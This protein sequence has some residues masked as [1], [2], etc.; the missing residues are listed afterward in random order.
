MVTGGSS[1]LGNLQIPLKIGYPIPSPW[2]IIIFPMKKCPYLKVKI[3]QGQTQIVHTVP[4][5]LSGS[6]GTLGW[7]SS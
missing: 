4:A 3:P 2:F 6:C 1:I 7:A 5:V